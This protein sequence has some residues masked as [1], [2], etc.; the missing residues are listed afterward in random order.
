MI[1]ILIITSDV[2]N[3]DFQDL[4]LSSSKFYKSKPN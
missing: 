1:G 2:I 4:N 3:P